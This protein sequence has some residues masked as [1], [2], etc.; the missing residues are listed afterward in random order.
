[1][2]YALGFIFF[3]LPQVNSKRVISRYCMCK[4]YY[5]PIKLLDNFRETLFLF[6]IHFQL[7]MP[8]ISGPIFSF[9]SY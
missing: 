2:F 7:A 9:S 4:S 3:T 1:M 6:L 8:L 5:F